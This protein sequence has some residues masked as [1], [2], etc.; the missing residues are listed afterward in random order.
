VAVATGFDAEVT[1]ARDSARGGDSWGLIGMVL[2]ISRQAAQQR[3]SDIERPDRGFVTQRITAKDI[4]VGRIRLS[5]K[6]KRLLPTER[7]NIDVILNGTVFQVRWD[8]RNGPGRSRSGILAFGRGK[9]KSLDLENKVL[10]IRA[11]STGA[12]E[13]NLNS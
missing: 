13:L 12:V 9:L 10:A 11:A 4:E 1:G 3:F 2:G 7:S 8:P 6:S 5:A